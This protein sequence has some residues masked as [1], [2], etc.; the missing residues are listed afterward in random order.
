[1]AT[2]ITNSTAR[3]TCDRYSVI[4]AVM[5][6]ISA[7]PGCY[8]I[9]LAVISPA[10]FVVVALVSIPGF[11]LLVGY[12]KEVRGR[13]RTAAFWC[14]SLVYQIVG[15]ITGCLLVANSMGDQ[16]VTAALGFTGWMI[17]TTAINGMVLTREKNKR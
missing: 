14:W 8:G 3:A 9:V 16:Q 17:A 4:M 7:L 5:A 15:V 12:W 11:V 10:I 13:P 2:L 1:M 6:S